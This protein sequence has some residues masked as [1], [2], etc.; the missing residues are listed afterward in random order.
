MREE[1]SGWCRL[2]DI[3]T[4]VT[5]ASFPQARA[6]NDVLVVSL[7]VN[8]TQFGPSEDLDRYPR[9]LDRDRALTKEAGVDVLFLPSMETMYPDGPSHQEVWVEPGSLATYLDGASRPS[10]FRGVAT[11]VTKLFNLVQP[12]RSYFGQKDFQ[13]AL[14]VQRMARDLAFDT[15]I[16]IVPTVRDD[17]GLAVSSRNVFL[18]SHEREQATVI[19]RALDLA[20]TLI[21]EGQRD[22][23][24]IVQRMKALIERDA[25]LGRIDFIEAASTATLAPMT[26]ITGDAVIA[27]A[28]YVGDTRL[29]DNTVVRFV[30]GV[31]HFQ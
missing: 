6:D 16:V 7:F 13:Q 19:P 10:H 24:L 14:I 25:P 18:S 2:W 11:V 30:D 22:S 1:A 12:Q 28:M 8:P 4:Q 29:I 15:C 17:D 9:D 26:T 3:S 20:R 23:G 31:P 21:A 27:L 5:C